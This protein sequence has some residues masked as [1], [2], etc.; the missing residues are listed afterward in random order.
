M[1]STTIKGLD[2]GVRI[3]LGAD[4][5]IIGAVMDRGK[6]VDCL[7]YKLVLTGKELLSFI[8]EFHLQSKVTQTVVETNRYE[9]TSY[10]D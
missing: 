3:E 6:A 10:D 4:V 8:E 1:R 7:I 5:G 2:D 9:L